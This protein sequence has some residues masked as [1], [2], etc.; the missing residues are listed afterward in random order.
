MFPKPTRWHS[1]GLF[2]S[3]KSRGD[4]EDGATGIAA[5]KE[6]RIDIFRLLQTFNGYLSAT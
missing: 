1:V 4:E 3:S 5:D 6:M 2:E